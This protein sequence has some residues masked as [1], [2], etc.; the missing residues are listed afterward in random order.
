MMTRKQVLPGVAAEAGVAVKARVRQ[1]VLLLV[2]LRLII[3]L[4]NV[5]VPHV[6][7]PVLVRVNHCVRELAGWEVNDRLFDQIIS[8]PEI[9]I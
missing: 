6:N 7:Q 4:I 2:G 5:R 3:N 1:V 8:Y 9:L